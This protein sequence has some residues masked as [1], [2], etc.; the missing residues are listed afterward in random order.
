MKKLGLIAPLLIL[1]TW[2]SSAQAAVWEMAYARI[3]RPS[4]AMEEP[5][6][7]RYGVSECVDADVESHDMECEIAD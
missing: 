7:V 4:L 5:E 6:V 1:S 2:L 3:D